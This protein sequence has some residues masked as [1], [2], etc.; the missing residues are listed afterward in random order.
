MNEMIRGADRMGYD[1]A[2]EEMRAAT[3]EDTT[4]S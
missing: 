3:V 4:E 2:F 1:K